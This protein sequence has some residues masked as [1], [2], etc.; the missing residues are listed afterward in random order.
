VLV[1][2]LHT[3]LHNANAHVRVLKPLPTVSA[4]RIDVLFHLR[5]KIDSNAVKCFGK[6]SIAA[7]LEKKLFEDL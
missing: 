4:V 3:K 1:S 2:L 5:A 7:K 6:E